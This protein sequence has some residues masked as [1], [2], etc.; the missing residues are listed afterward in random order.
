MEVDPYLGRMLDN[1]YELLER[2]GTG[3]MALVYKAK[4]HRLNR[5]VA[6]K[7]LKHDL[8]QDEDFRRRFQAESQ[9][10]AQLSSPNIVSVYDVSRDDG[11]DYIVMELIDGVTLKQYIEERGRLPWREALHI[12]TQIM[13]GLSHAHARGIIHRD[14]KPQN[15]MVLRDGSVKVTDFG[16]A[17]LENASQTLTQQ[18]LGS[19]HYISPEQARGERADSRSDIYSAG[20]VLY[21][22]LT[23]RQ[24]FRGESAV[25][26]ALQH[27]SSVPPSP[28][29]LCPDIPEQMELICLK[30][31]A[32][33]LSR[34]Y[35]SAEEMIR[36]L[37]DFRGNPEIQLNFQISDVRPAAVPEE[38]TQPMGAAAP[39]PEETRSPFQRRAEIAILG[40]GCLLAVFLALFFLRSITGAFDR[41]KAPET[42]VVK[43]LVGYTVAQAKNLDGVKGIFDVQEEGQEP[44]DDY[45]RGAIVRQDPA[46][47][48]TQ[49]GQ[50]LV[51]R[52]WVSAGEEVALMPKVSGQTVS[53]AEKTTLR[54]LIQ[55]FGLVIQADEADMQYNASIPAGQ[56]I[57]SIPSA[58]AELR[59]GD[60]I[61]LFLSKGERIW[62]L[63]PF[64][65]LNYFDDVQQQL[66]TLRLTKGDIRLE[67][68]DKPFG[69]ILSQDPAPMTPVK[70]GTAVS[71]T[72]SQ[73]PSPAI[74]PVSP[75]AM[76]A[77]QPPEMEEPEEPVETP[78]T[79]QTPET[80][81]ETAEPETETPVGPVPL[82]VSIPL[83]G[84]RER[85]YLVVYQ[86]G[87]RIFNGTV[88]C[89]AGS[90]SLEV[91]PDGEAQT[92]IEADV[93]GREV[94]N[95]WIDTGAV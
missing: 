50:N 34:R 78:E 22:M 79:P 8:A 94:L 81:P 44:S 39:V 54:D 51:I 82:R 31:M 53:Q 74:V 26:V 65:G 95:R 35:V 36:D 43:N 60:T 13:R 1:R 20:V 64:V 75:A 45:P 91:D 17:C 46:A 87:S 84:D 67:Y 30:A 92:H 62:D 4:C 42:Y 14:I 5:L 49:K 2:V 57:T 32:P 72:I 24:P 55:R 59:K 77:V 33:D 38:P 12:I 70:D 10:V 83:P 52:V 61:R 69:T 40:A 89:T 66:G 16:I 58:G 85:G 6:V 88:D 11:V 21:E 15:I 9:A 76:P 90:F 56:I 48:R 93:D 37:E 41:E 73:G 29:S 27:L 80:P 68:S 28:R 18:A 63:P 25:S 71:F 19:V 47:N 86:D 3:G 23:G 7:I